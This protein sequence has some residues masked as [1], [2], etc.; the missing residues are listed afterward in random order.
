VVGCLNSDE[1]AQAY[2]ISSMKTGREVIHS[3]RFSMTEFKW[4]Q[5]YDIYLSG[6]VTGIHWK[7]ED[8]L[9]KII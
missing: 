5:A 8:V 7:P 3:Q 1:I 2:G 9:D 4:D 6:I